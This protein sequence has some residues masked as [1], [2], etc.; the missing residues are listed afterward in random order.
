MTKTKVATKRIEAGFYQLEAEGAPSVFVRRFARQGVRHIRTDAKSWR[1][2]AWAMF[3]TR[4]EATRAH[5]PPTPAWASSLE[6]ARQRLRARVE[7]ER[8]ILAD[9]DEDFEEEVVDICEPVTVDTM[10]K[11]V[12]ANVEWLLKREF[13]WLPGWRVRWSPHGSL[14]HEAGENET[15]DKA[16]VR[17]E[18]DLGNGDTVAGKALAD[19]L[20]YPK[21]R[22]GNP[23]TYEGELLSVTAFIDNANA[24]ALLLA[25]NAK[26]MKNA[27]AAIA[28]ALRQRAEQVAARRGHTLGP[29]EESGQGGR[30][31]GA[32]DCTRCGR[33]VVYDTAP[34]ANGIDLGGRAVA[35]EC[36]TP[37]EPR[38]AELQALRRG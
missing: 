36:A 11:T 5:R 35:V 27:D 17:F 32:A 14:F 22:W 8:G 24:G 9:E 6:D 23:G 16:T 30:L 34:P 31:R 29:W 4:R 19:I 10:E 33:G 7:R 3:A 28:A 2:D 12:A 26:Q 37:L 25:R 18:V 20:G 1:G 15:T 38:E 21:D 13:L